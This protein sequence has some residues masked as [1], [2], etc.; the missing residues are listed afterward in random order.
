MAVNVLRDLPAWAVA[1]LTAARVGHLATAAES[2]QPH[3]VPVCFVIDGERLYW[4]VDD[5]PKR[6]R[7]LR[8][9][10]NIEDNPRVALVVDQWDEDWTRLAWVMVEGTAAVVDGAAERARALD[11]LT[12]KYPQYARMS[13]AT[14]AGAVV[15]IAPTRARAWRATD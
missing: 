7:A 8:R 4:A 10:R 12:A 11:R 9:L 3:V 14:T 2:A 13:L 15:A 6:T 1:M 5:K